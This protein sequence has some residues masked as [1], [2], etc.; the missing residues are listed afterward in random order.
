ML[1]SMEKSLCIFI[2]NLKSA[3]SVPS[4]CREGVVAQKI[5]RRGDLKLCSKNQL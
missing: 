1:K 3:G 4:F 5:G 2:L